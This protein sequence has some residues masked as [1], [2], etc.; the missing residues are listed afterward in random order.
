MIVRKNSRCLVA[1]MFFSVAVFCLFVWR[2]QPLSS[3]LTEQKPRCSVEVIRKYCV[4]HNYFPTGGH[5]LNSSYAPDICR[6]PSEEIT[7]EHL[8]ECLSQRNVTK[9]VVLGDSNG[10]RYFKATMRLLKKFLKCRGVK[11]EIGS[12]MPDVNYFTQGT[13]LNSSDIFVH[14]RD[15][16]GCK[17]AAVSCTDKDTEIKLEY[18]VM[19]FFLDTEM[20]TVRNRWQKNCHPSKDVPECHQSNTYQEFLLSEYLEGNYPDVILLFSP[21]HDKAR[22]GR[23]KIRS[24]MEYLKMLIDIYVPKQTR[25]FWFSKISENQ[26]QKAGECCHATAATVIG[27]Q[28]MSPQMATVKSSLSVTTANSYLSQQVANTAA[29]PDNLSH[30]VAIA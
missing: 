26:R 5:W 23:S 28:I 1:A 25:I 14:P 16:M 9:L 13:K 20:T 12:T 3:Y 10:L 11:G 24:D 6:V 7:T 30:L 18:I 2:E 17:S 27:T 22:S 19:E 29:R 8:R 15:C 21:S 4:K